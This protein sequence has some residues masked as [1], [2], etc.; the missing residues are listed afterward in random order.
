MVG[1]IAFIFSILSILLAIGSVWV[2][3]LGIRRV[4]R[5]VRAK[6]AKEIA[7]DIRAELVCC[8]I[9]DEDVDTDRAG[10]R[11]GICFWGEAAA[12]IAEDFADESSERYLN[13]RMH[14][15]YR[16]AWYSRQEIHETASGKELGP[17]EIDQLAAEAEAGYDVDYLRPRRQRKEATDD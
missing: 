6:V 2:T 11:H 7:Y 9:Y 16:D 3:A 13:S 1:L 17:E 14:V 4:K 10:T 5:R 15:T 12:R 8:E